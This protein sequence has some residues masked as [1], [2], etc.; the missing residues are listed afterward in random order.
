MCIDWEYLYMGNKLWQVSKMTKT[1]SFQSILG[2]FQLKKQILCTKTNDY[3]SMNNCGE[4]TYLWLTFSIERIMICEFF[5]TNPPDSPVVLYWLISI[6]LADFLSS[7]G[8]MV[9]VTT[10]ACRIRKKYPE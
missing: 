10:L 3:Y 1:C 7:M 4:I 5:M 6:A 8:T 9:L 2:D